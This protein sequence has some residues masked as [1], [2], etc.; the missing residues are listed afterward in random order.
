MWAWIVGLLGCGWSGEPGLLWLEV[1][2]GDADRVAL[3]VPAGWI[4]DQAEPI[5]LET[6]SGP[7][8]LRGEV[9]SLSAQRIGARRTWTLE[10]GGSDLRLSHEAPSGASAD[11]LTVAALGK[12]GKGL[13]LSFPLEPG[14]LGAAQAGLDAHLDVDGL[15]LQLDVLCAQLRRAGP[16]ILL[17]TTGPKG[18]GLRLATE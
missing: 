7:I 1:E 5:T 14:R 3:R 11:T 12:K 17:E 15:D 4:A 9:R 6:T 18:G 10:E 8:D 16:T 13:T 2:G